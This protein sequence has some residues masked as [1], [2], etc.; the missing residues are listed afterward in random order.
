M[1]QFHHRVKFFAASLAACAAI[2]VSPAKG[3]TA[4]WSLQALT[5]P[6]VPEITS[7]ERVANPIDAF[8]LQKLKAAGLDYSP[9]SSRQTLI[10]RVYFDLIGLPPKLE[11]VE[12]FVQ[13]S[14][15][16]AYEHLVDRLLSLPQHGERWA[17]HWLDVVHYGDTHGYDKDQPRPNAWPYRDYVIRAFNEDRPYARFVQEQIAGDVLF[18][19]TRDGI[20]ALGFISA[21]PW[22]LIGHAEVAETKTDGKIARHLDRD[23]MVANTINTFNS[24]TVQCAQCHNHKFDPIPSEDYYKLQAVFA[25]VDRTDREYYENPALN[26]KRSQLKGREQLLRT[27]EKALTEKISIEGGP[28]LAELTKQLEKA[29][30]PTG[31]RKNPQEHGYH[32]LVESRADTLKWVQLD[33]GKTVTLKKIVL[34]PCSDDFAGLG[35]GFGF[36]LRYRVEISTNSDF[37]N[38]QVLADKS[39]ADQP[40]PGITPQTISAGNQFARFI[41]ITATRLALRQN[42]YILALAEV[43][44]IDAAGNNPARSG[45]VSALDSIESPV[46]WSKSNLVDGIFPGAPAE[47][48]STEITAVQSRLS[49]LI[50]EKISATTRA[51]WTTVTNELASVTR[52]LSTMPRPLVTFIGGVHYGSGAFQGTGPNGGKPRQICILPR[53]DVRHPGRE[54]SP[55]ALSALS[56]LPSIFDLPPDAPE[57]ER[58]RALALWLTDARNPLTWRSIVNRV[59]Q[60]HFGRGIVGSPNDFGRMG[61]LPSH[62]ELLDWLAV[63]FRDGGQSLKKLHKLMLMSAAYRQSSSPSSGTERGLELDSDNRLLWRAN[64]RK[65]EAE[66]VRDSVLVVSRQLDSRMSGPGFRDFVVEKPEHSPHY[67]YEKF[68]P[69]DIRARRRSIY[70]FIV[71]SQQQPFMTTLDCADPSMLVARR[72]ES[73][74]PLQALALLNNGFVLTMAQKFA[75]DLKASE[76][77]ADRRIE[78]AFARALSRSP[79]RKE[80]AE[81]TDFTR[82]NGLPNM[83]RLLFNLNE[84]NFVD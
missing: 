6:P 79:S 4:W 63:E 34:R 76:T 75:D 78:G 74:S 47:R 70:R 2:A 5:R 73:V 59:W 81:L 30:H 77:D 17:R 27:E 12:L 16:Q 52:E 62:P 51:R 57:G 32:S 80:L 22:D 66:A 8:L 44:A 72:N 58:R 21:G 84:F 68:D 13:D 56:E 48:S 11:D 69:D 19:A 61:E 23:D 7:G 67:E 36:P 29:E 25:A 82:K 60:Y 37:S 42:D 31:G 15:P 43:E 41:R 71:R 45:T 50:S 14:D 54:V 53:G 46:R 9:E 33:L 55:G 28:R 1:L 3:D 18:P 26:R 83:C 20:E 10:R 38:A 39:D 64:R 49:D 40:N 24:L 35:D 65:L